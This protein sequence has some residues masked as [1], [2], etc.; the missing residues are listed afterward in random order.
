[1]PV[2]V[3]IEKEFAFEMGFLLFL[4]INK[5]KEYSFSVVLSVFLDIINFNGSLKKCE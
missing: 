5:C 2:F 3:I 4:F 1:M